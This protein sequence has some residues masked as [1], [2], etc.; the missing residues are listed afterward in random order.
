MQMNKWVGQ[1]A[2][3]LLFMGEHGK[4]SNGEDGVDCDEW[5]GEDGVDCDEENASLSLWCNISFIL[6]R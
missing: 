2:C 1:K 6:R 3:A 4:G 5:D